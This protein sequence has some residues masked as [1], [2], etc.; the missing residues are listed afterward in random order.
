MFIIFREYTV[1]IRRFWLILTDLNLL[2]HGLLLRHL[3]SKGEV[4]LRFLC[5]YPSNSSK[6]QWLCF[7]IISPIH[8]VSSHHS[9]FR[10]CHHNFEWNSMELLILAMYWPFHILPF[11]VT[12]TE[13]GT[14]TVKASLYLKRQTRNQIIKFFACFIFLF[15]F[16]FNSHMSYFTSLQ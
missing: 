14:D 6:R 12:V 16:Y 13:N 11:K 4:I 1:I 3:C 9:C 15:F 2:E 7:G 10:H 8:H 5:S